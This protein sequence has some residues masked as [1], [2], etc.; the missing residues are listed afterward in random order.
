MASQSNVILT[1]GKLRLELSPSVGGSIANFE[2][3]DGDTPQPILR[4]C[5]NRL[6]NVLDAASF[7]QYWLRGVAVDPLEIDN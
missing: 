4:K 1:A 3:I 7:P 6:E 5:N 2:W